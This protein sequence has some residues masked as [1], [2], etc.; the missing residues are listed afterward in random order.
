[1]MA[2]AALVVLLPRNKAMPLDTRL[3]GFLVSY[4]TNEV[5]LVA[6]LVAF[7]LTQMV[8]Y[9]MDLSPRLKLAAC[10]FVSALGIVFLS[11]SLPLLLLWLCAILVKLLCL[12]SW[13]LFFLMFTAALLPFGAGI[14]T[15]IHGLFAIIVAAYVTSLGWLKAEKALSFFK[16]SYVFGAAI[17][18]IIV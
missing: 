17:P 8:V 2:I 10:L 13:S 14:G 5:N 9:S 7:L 18:S 6:S 3:F 15:P 16:T 11:K 1:M 4:Q 12:R